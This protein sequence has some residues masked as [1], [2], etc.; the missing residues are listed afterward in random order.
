MFV[1]WFKNV[2]ANFVYVYEIYATIWR[3]HGCVMI[4]VLEISLDISKFELQS[5][6]FELIPL[7][8]VCTHLSPQPLIK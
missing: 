2:S 1:D 6:I 4:K 3:S 7:G 8:K 5:F